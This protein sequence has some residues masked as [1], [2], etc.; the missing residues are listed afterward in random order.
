MLGGARRVRPSAV[1]ISRTLCAGA[2]DY[3]K[4]VKLLIAQDAAQAVHH[5]QQAA[6]VGNAKAQSALGGYYLNKGTTQNDAVSAAKY[7]AMAADQGHVRSN[8]LLGKLFAEG[9]GVDADNAKAFKCLKFAAEQVGTDVVFLRYP[10]HI[11]FAA[12]GDGRRSVGY[13][14]RSARPCRA[15]CK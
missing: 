8:Y 7:L 12:A 10:F 4:G 14:I 15:K 5:W 11:A 1:V 9:N 13:G 6:E 3:T 2:D